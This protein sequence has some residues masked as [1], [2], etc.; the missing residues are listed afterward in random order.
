M[1]YMLDTNICIY[2]VIKKPQKV[3]E[4][5]EEEN[6]GD[7][8]ISSI[9]YAELRT[10]VEK[11]E[12]KE[13]DEEALRNLVSRI[14]VVNFDDNAGIEYGIL[15]TRVPDRTRDAMDRLI[16]SHAISLDYTLVT[17]NVDDFKDYP[18]LK[19]ENWLTSK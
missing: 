6:E 9:T 1:K 8:V 3:F 15:R 4:R 11:S 12:E 18:S 19:Y 10:G 13:A 16:A 7:V 17:N 2:L 14:P 5:L